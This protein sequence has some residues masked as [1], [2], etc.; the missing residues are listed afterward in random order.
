[1]KK[2][3][4]RTVGVF[5]ATVMLCL[6]A[7]PAYAEEKHKYEPE[8]MNVGD[9]IY[10]DNSETGWNS[11]K[12]YMWGNS[13]NA[14]VGQDP[15]DWDDR[16]SMTRVGDTDIWEYEIPTVEEFCSY[17]VG[18]GYFDNSLDCSDYYSLSDFGRSTYDWLWSDVRNLLF[19]DDASSNGKQTSDLSYVVSGFVYK[20]TNAAGTEG[21]LYL[22]DRVNLLNLLNDGKEYASKIS[23][24]EEEEAQRFVTE[25]DGLTLNVEGSGAVNIEYDYDEGDYVYWANTDEIDGLNTLITNMINSIKEKYGD[26]PTV[27]VE[28]ATDD[29]TSDES[30]DDFVNPD[31]LDSIGLYI[32][33]GVASFTGLAISLNIKRRA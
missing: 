22:Y 13:G 28:D 1:M 2:S 31:T 21:E 6:G 3:L 17:L 14:Y 29:E 27:C 30:D 15:F 16:P 19:T 23:C 10:Y 18:K 8:G 32:G 9:K 5:V 25:I 20:S 24:V 4:L 7:L 26:E 11:V 12:V 33:L